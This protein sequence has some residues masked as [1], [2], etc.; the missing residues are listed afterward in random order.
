MKQLIEALAIFAK[1]APDLSH[2]TCC[3]HD[4]LYVLV[5][6]VLVSDEDKARLAELSFRPSSD[7]PDAFSS[8]RFGSA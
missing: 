4:V 5:P 7:V 1:Y 3:D 8:F 6:P 2:P